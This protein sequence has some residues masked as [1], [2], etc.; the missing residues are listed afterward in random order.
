MHSEGSLGFEFQAPDTMV[1]FKK[2]LLRFWSLLKKGLYQETLLGNKSLV[3]WW[4]RG[5]GGRWGKKKW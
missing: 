3:Q 1:N 4:T 5:G 2:Q